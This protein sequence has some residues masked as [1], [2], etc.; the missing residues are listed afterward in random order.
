MMKSIAMKAAAIAVALVCAVS[1]ASAEVRP[2]SGPQDG[3]IRYVTYSANDVIV[4]EA[5]YGASTMIMF[6]DDEQIETLGAGD[7]MAWNIEP[8]KKGNV[9]FVKPIEKDTTANLN[10]LTNKRSYVLLLRAE[11]RPIRQQ[12][13][14]VSFRYPDDEADKALMA[15][16]VERASQ[17]N[18]QQF[19]VANANSAY[20]YKGA[21]ANKPVAIFDDGV[22]TFFRFRKSAEVPAMF[23]VDADQNE[24]LVNFRRE[25]EYIVVD[26]VAKQW[27]LRNGAAVTCVFNLRD[28][29]VYEPTGFEDNGPQRVGTHRPVPATPSNRR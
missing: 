19:N 13:Y 16:A 2:R 21:S 25:G 18:R 29:D 17:P 12:I 1:T 11:F 7:A 14:K 5:S 26:K 28:N 10:V 15:E 3:R 9:L 8:N 27:T 22:K 23:I 6:Q 24:T 4:I 20:G